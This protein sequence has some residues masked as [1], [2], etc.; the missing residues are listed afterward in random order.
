MSEGRELPPLRRGVRWAAP[1]RRPAT[2]L[3]L[4]CTARLPLGVLNRQDVAQAV[5]PLVPRGGP[6]SEGREMPPLP[7]ADAAT[8]WAAPA[9]LAS[10]GV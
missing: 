2:Q 6:M 9:A 10:A 4:K 3:A 7:R 5:R 1:A 8:R